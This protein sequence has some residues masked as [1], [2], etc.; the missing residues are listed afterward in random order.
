MILRGLK[1]AAANRILP[2]P[3]ALVALL[4]EHQAAQGA[5][6]RRHGPEWNARGLV[7]VG[8]TGGPL[9][10]PHLTVAFQKLVAAAGLPPMRFHDL[11]HCAASFLGADGVPVEVAKAL[12]GHT[13]VRLTLNLY[14]HIQPEEYERAAAAMERRLAKF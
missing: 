9:D 10:G 8:R 5:L 2:L 6:R 1:S 12:L 11:R 7:F 13:D 3:P 14:R 4:R